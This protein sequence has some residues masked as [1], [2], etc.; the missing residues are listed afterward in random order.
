MH[1][2]GNLVWSSTNYCFDFKELL[3]NKVINSNSVIS[4]YIWYSYW[5]F[6]NFK[7]S[8]DIHQERVVPKAGRQVLEGA[9]KLESHSIFNY[10]CKII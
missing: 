6:R 7:L 3:I 10:L 5:D 8:G 9:E 1:L 4:V 2:T